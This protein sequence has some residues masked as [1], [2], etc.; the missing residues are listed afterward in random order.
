MGDWVGLNCRVWTTGS[1]PPS[2]TWPWPLSRHFSG[3]LDPSCSA[4]EGRE[5]LDRACTNP[6]GCEPP[7]SDGSFSTP[8]CRVWKLEWVEK[9]GWI[10]DILLRSFYDLLVPWFYLCLYEIS[11]NNCIQDWYLV[12]E[13]VRT[14]LI[15]NVFNNSLIIYLFIY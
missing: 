14:A 2:T 5:L 1:N 4:L 7:I 8:E 12:F 10:D 13:K 9:S 6:A 11:E 15:C 3:T